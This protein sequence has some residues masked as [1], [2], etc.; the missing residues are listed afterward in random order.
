M[1]Q[2]SVLI[3]CIFYLVSSNFSHAIPAEGSKLMI[4]GPS[5]HAVQVGKLV[6]A[7]GGNV[8]DVAVAIGL[9]LSVTG[10]YFAA[11]GG[12][13]FALIKM[14]KETNVLDFREV[15]PIAMHEKY[16]VKKAK[17]SSITG[18]TAVGVP[19]FPA[20]L[21]EMHKK[22]GK[23]KWRKLF[24]Y[25]LKLALQGFHVSG[26]WVSK[27]NYTKNRFNNYGKK[28]FFKKGGVSYRPGELLKQPKLAKALNLLKRYKLK[29][30][31]NGV[32]ARDI[33]KSVKEAGGELSL[34]DMKAYKPTWRKPLTAEYNGYTLKLMPPPSSGGVVIKT[35]FELV[36]KLEMS[37]YK[38]FSVEEY[39]MLGE[40]LSRSFRGRALLGDPGFYQNPLDKI[41]SEKYISEMVDSISKRKTK[42]L[43]P[44]ADE[45]F[46]SNETT[47]YSI[48]DKDGNAVA[49]TVT[50]NGRY[51]SGV[52]SRKYGIALNNEMDDFTTRPGKSNMFGLIQ[53][54]GNY[55]QA[56]KRPLSSMSPTI[57]E[58]NGKAVM[59]IGA[60]GGP[61]IISGVFQ[62]LYRVLHS[63]LNMDQ[64]IQTPRVHHQ[65]LPHKLFI[66]RARFTPETIEG[67][68]DKG[69]EVE[70]SWNSRVYGVR[71]NKE[72]NLEAAHDLRGE[73]ASGGF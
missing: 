70:E 61:R 11:L 40:I 59:S 2:L 56:G 58:K 31:Y 36:K 47:H 50:L 16:Y 64:A 34:S 22:Y 6:A 35:A 21:Y 45:T 27:T 33:V 26:E 63:N 17:D 28:H 14:G 51:G 23:L 24:K 29:P 68:E 73:G 60:P 20:G 62:G 69:H 49:L 15:A 72:G 66:D 65:F 54:K 57:V 52:V 5:P 25:P 10:P 38:R 8:V 13:G 3:F 32:I 9:T 19:G 18:G 41:L 48:L 43:D 71:L 67:L 55:V 4:A 46:E 39:H 12:G 42:K 7:E 30:F 37:K 44:L 53:G 1:K